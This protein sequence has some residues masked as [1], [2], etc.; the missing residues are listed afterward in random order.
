[1]TSGGNERMRLDTSGNLGL[2][3]IPSATTSGVKSFEL[4]GVGS[5]LVSFGSVDTVVTAGAFYST[6]GWKYSVSS[7]AVSY[8]YQAAGAHQWFNAASGTAGNALTATQAMTLNTSGNLGIGVTT[9]TERVHI[10]NSAAS[11]NAVAQ[12][13]NGTTG[14]AAAN[15]LY[16][17]IDSIND[18]TVFNFYN[19]ALKF[20][21]NGNEGMRLTGGNLLL[22]GG[23]IPSNTSRLVVRGFS[24]G[25]YNT[26]F[27]QSNATV[28]IISN[29][30][31]N[32][33]WNPTLNI[34]MVRQS[35]TTGANSFGGIGF[36]TIDD[37]NDAGMHDA[38]RIAIVN[39]QSSAVASPTAMAFYTQ[40]GSATQTNAAT[41]RMRITST[42]AVILGYNQ[43]TLTSVVK[44]FAT[45]HAAGNQGGEVRFG[46]NDG[47]FGG[48]IIPN[49]ASSIPA[50]NSQYIQFHTHQ[51]A[52]SAGE[53]MRITADG[54]LLV[55]TTTATGKL[56]VVGAAAGVAGYFSDSVNSSL[57]IATLSGGVTLGTDGGGQIHLATDGATA[58][59]RRLSIDSSGNLLVNTTNGVAGTVLTL[60]NPSSAT[61][62]GSGPD[63]NGTYLV[64]N[65]SSVGVYLGSG[66]TSWSSS[67]DERTK[68]AITPFKNAL[69][70]VCTLRAGTGRY[71]KDEETV[72]RSFLIAQDVQAVLPEA[73][74]VQNDE[75]GTLGL[76][77][78]D[79][80]PLLVAAIQEQQVMITALTARVA[81]LEN[82]NK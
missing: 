22:T 66:S 51:G 36:S 25:G 28:Q 32:D 15:G 37:S 72:S 75:I 11:T 18:A 77:Y 64:Y 80:I 12:F 70:K 57:V 5:G 20:G 79:V 7:S 61:V 33:I 3:V 6:T 19:S 31:S 16:V 74:N 52:V 59:K 40:V 63:T 24:G 82:L 50:H 21:T 73:V 54:N 68:T 10:S 42:G 49:V 48:I 35:L 81:E 27:S 71:L 44:E 58:A 41:E 34:A 13:T 60:K 29:E 69:E 56:T 38:G 14:T 47:S 39:E 45:S 23:F 30:M 9:A 62:W 65:A 8:Y 55:G 76:Q 46:I 53:R 26:V 67:S 43:A 2:G 78:T 4:Q 17:G 1:M